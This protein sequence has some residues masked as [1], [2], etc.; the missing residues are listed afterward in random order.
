VTGT[1]CYVLSLTETTSHT[2]GSRHDRRVLL[3]HGRAALNP[4]RHGDPS[5]QQGSCHGSSETKRRALA[6]HRGRNGDLVGGETD[7]R[8][9]SPLS[10]ALTAWAPNLDSSRTWISAGA[11]EVRKEPVMSELHAWSRRAIRAK[12]ARIWKAYK[13]RP[14]PQR[15][16][17]APGVLHGSPP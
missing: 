3:R 14:T 10:T 8:M 4:S 16:G 1:F 11:V 2:S 17:A 5:A 7:A 6:K 13:S 12:L 15:G 9:V